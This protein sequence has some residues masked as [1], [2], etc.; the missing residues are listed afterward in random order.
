MELQ[1]SDWSIGR[2]G[3]G[4]YKDLSRIEAGLNFAIRRWL[5]HEIA[6]WESSAVNCTKDFE[7]RIHCEA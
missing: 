1:K 2:S 4:S 3:I 6:F 7:V 5:A